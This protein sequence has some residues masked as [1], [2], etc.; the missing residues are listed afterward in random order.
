MAVQAFLVAGGD[1]KISDPGF[2]QQFSIEKPRRVLDKNRVGRVQLGKGLFVLTLD[3]DLRFRGHCPA[4]QV[5]H[6]F[7]PQAV[8]V[9]VK[10]R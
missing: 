5:D 7:K 6:I 4:T 10:H 2:G 9:V 8:V 1:T 3:H